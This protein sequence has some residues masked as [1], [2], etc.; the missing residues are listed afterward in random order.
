MSSFSQEII[1]ITG[2]SRS[3]KS[4]WAEFLAASKGLTVIYLATGYQDPTDLEWYKRIEKHQKRRSSDWQTIEEQSDLCGVLGNCS[5]GN[6]LL[7]DSLGTWVA[8]LLQE[9]EQLWYSRVEELLIALSKS[10]VDVILVAEETGWG[11]FLLIQWVDY[12][13]IA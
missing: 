8:N 2:P 10:T 7:I 3:G 9:E 6:C 11:W 12:L 4:E 1:L 13:G 5:P